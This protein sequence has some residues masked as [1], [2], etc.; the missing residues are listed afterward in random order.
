MEYHIRHAN[1]NDSH[2]L[3]NIHSLSFRTAYKGTIPDSVLDNFTVE[4]RERYINEDKM[5]TV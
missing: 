2:V 1:V 4:K 5:L 3:S